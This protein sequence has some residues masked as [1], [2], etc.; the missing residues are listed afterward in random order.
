MGNYSPRKAS[1]NDK[2]IAK[3]VSDIAGVFTDPII[4]YPGGW[5]EDTPTWLRQAIVIER[6]CAYLSSASMDGPMDSD[7][8]D[9]YLYIATKVYERH[10]SK[11]M[12]PDIAV[13]EISQYQQ[14]EL[15]RLKRW[16]YERRSRN[17]QERERAERREEKAKKV[18][19]GIEALPLFTWK[20]K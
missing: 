13:R 12:S 17:R 14:G 19:Q 2:E 15:I 9:I 16:I 7:W 6:M 1:M 10:K 8:S 3:V 18:D 11:Q 5:G 20:E 4:C